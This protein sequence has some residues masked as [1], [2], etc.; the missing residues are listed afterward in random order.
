MFNG[1]WVVGHGSN[2]ACC[3]RCR[4]S[5]NFFTCVSSWQSRAEIQFRS[6]KANLTWTL[7]RLAGWRLISAMRILAFPPSFLHTRWSDSRL[8]EKS[9]LK[10]SK[11][12]KEIVKFYPFFS[13]TSNSFRIRSCSDPGWFFPD[14]YPDP[15]KSLRSD[16]I[17][18]HNTEQQQWW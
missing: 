2:G 3:I 5:R 9:S 7:G 1:S 12:W 14:P 15:A 18:I 13:F 8:N 16:R 11:L 17:F 4:N 6:L 10:K